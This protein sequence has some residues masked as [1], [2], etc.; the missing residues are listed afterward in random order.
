QHRGV[1]RT[2]TMMLVMAKSPVRCPRA[3]GL[4]WSATE[5]VMKKYMNAVPVKMLPTN[6]PSPQRTMEMSTNQSP[7]VVYKTMEI[8]SDENRVA[9]QLEDAFEASSTTD[10]D[11]IAAV[12]PGHFRGWLP[13]SRD[14]SSYEGIEPL[15]DT[16]CQGRPRQVDAG[17][18]ASMLARDV[19]GQNAALAITSDCR[20]LIEMMAIDTAGQHCNSGVFE[21]RCELTKPIAFF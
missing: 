20:R 7:L 9:T 19:S 10:V 16:C 4:A 5:L 14:L 3:D 6:E 18:G 1:E 11:F 17:V 15:N 21:L 12:R 13:R 8:S 2:M